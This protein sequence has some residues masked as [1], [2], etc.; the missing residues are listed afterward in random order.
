MI[1]NNHLA[2]L[3]VPLL[4]VTVSCSS[5][6]EP[7]FTQPTVA[8]IAGAQ[9]ESIPQLETIPAAG[10]FTRT[11]EAG[12]WAEP[13]V[14]NGNVNLPLPAA[15]LGE[16]YY[17]EVPGSDGSMEFIAY[18]AGGELHIRASLCP[19]CGGTH[20]TFTHDALVCPLCDAR[21]ALQTGAVMA[22][23]RSYPSGAIPVTSHESY[24]TSPL[25]SLTVAYERTA[26]GET[27]LYKLPAQPDR[28]SCAGCS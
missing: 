3:V 24:V 22:G 27:T 19:S 5:P 11:S 28:F 18:E 4:A 16:Y 17:F 20:I 25:H 9:V 7:S 2:L 8:P 6:V 26:S 13:V 15:E 23:S 21:F 10:P 12:I 14:T 1:R